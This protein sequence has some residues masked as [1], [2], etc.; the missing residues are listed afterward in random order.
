MVPTMSGARAPSV[1]PGANLDESSVAASAGGASRSR[2]FFISMTS[3]GSTVVVSFASM[4]TARPFRSRVM[5]IKCLAPS[6]AAPPASCILTSRILIA[7]GKVTSSS[8]RRSRVCCNSRETCRLNA[9][10]TC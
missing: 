5:L 10:S 3:P 9:A 2:S 4:T 7:A 8:L 6:D 1:F